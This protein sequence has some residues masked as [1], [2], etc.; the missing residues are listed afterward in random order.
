MSAVSEP[1]RSWVPIGSDNISSGRHRWRV[2]TRTCIALRGVEKPWWAVNKDEAGCWVY[3]MD[4]GIDETEGIASAR[5][6][7]KSLGGSEKED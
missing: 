6:E 2:S 3:I 7:E 1:A 5:G 4:V